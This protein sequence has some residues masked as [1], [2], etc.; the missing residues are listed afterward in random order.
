M[1]QNL[2]AAADILSGNAP[3]D[4]PEDAALAAWQSLFFVVPVVSTTFASF[5]R[6]FCHLGREALGWLLIDE[7]GQATPQ[8]AVGALW[9]SKR[10]VIV[11][12]PLQL[13]PVTT[14]PL[15]A[16]Q[17]IRGDHGVDEQWLSSSTSVQRLADRLT[18][19]G[20]WL[21]GDDGRIWVGAPL[22]VHRRC[23]Q[24]MFGIA[25][26]VAYDGLMISKTLPEAA[27]KFD[28]KYPSLPKS[29]WIDVVS[30]ESQGHWI[31]AEG[32]ELDKILAVLKSLDFDMSQVM[33]IAPFRDIAQR[34]RQQAGRY[35][36]L[37][38]GT[39]HTAQGKEANIVILV[40]GGNPQRA[41]AKSWAASKPNLLNVAVSRA[42]RRLYVIANRSEW[43]THRHFDVLADRL[44][45]SLPR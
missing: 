21:S 22:T 7:A 4:I 30:D 23:D 33:V 17:A 6:L 14:L 38:A 41:G 2:H 1:R 36:G 27:R 37:T 26:D 40:L 10:A 31:P 3:R 32:R 45:H 25:N 15:R 39:I 18:P 35:P 5:A 13:E 42:K 16:E 24:P 29:K 34:V 8:N 19:L 28:A 11:G 20:T 43:A 12:D 44:P 9:R